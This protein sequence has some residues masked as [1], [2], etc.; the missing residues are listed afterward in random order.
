[1]SSLSIE[2]AKFSKEALSRSSD[3]IQK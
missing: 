2:K 1:M 3:G